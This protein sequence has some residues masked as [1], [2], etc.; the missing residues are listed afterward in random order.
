MANYR[1]FLK[2]GEYNSGLRNGSLDYSIEYNLKL[3]EDGIMSRIITD[4][5]IYPS[6]YTDN[7]NV[8]KKI[9]LEKSEDTTETEYTLDYDVNKL[10][11]N[12]VQTELEKVQS[13]DNSVLTSTSY[14]YP[15][16]IAV[17][18][19]NITDND[20][21]DDQYVLKIELNNDIPVEY[22]TIGGGR[23]THILNSSYSPDEPFSNLNAWKET[24]DINGGSE[25]FPFNK[26]IYLLIDTTIS[27][28]VNI[29]I[30]N[31][32]NNNIIYKQTMLE[33]LNYNSS[34][35]Y[36]LD[37]SQI[38]INQNIKIT[39]ITTNPFNNDVYKIDDSNKRL[40][41]FTETD[42]FQ[43]DLFVEKFNINQSSFNYNPVIINNNFNHVVI[44]NT[45]NNNMHLEDILWFNGKLMILCNMFDLYTG[46]P[47]G[48]GTYDDTILLSLPYSDILEYNES[49]IYIIDPES[50]TPIGLQGNY[51]SMGKIN[52]LKS[53]TVDKD[54]NLL[55]S[56]NK[57]NKTYFGK[58]KPLYDYA[59]IDDTNIL[60]HEKYD[61]IITGE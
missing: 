54:G 45:I 12:K 5:S 42:E 36:D 44:N 31:A 27:D 57:D 58:V 4:A 48:S 51:I 19:E 8:P 25:V 1:K 2:V 53:I 37:K 35:F 60:F 9:I 6:L 41:K 56:Y 11:D 46:T 21:I 49:R 61:K 38:T 50:S 47:Y 33:S 28:D 15:Y 29:Q 24:K 14:I 26:I 16:N 13:S 34:S 30:N 3:N 23:V 22:I 40:L 32:V 59:Y 55:Y 52:I 39:G 10:W 18:E 20:S 17:L 43:Y 7:N